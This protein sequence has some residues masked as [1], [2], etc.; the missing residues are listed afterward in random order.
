MSALCQRWGDATGKIVREVKVPSEPDALL[1][2]LRKA[3]ASDV[4]GNTYPH[5]GSR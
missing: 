4:E 3:A 5:K 2:A 1:Q